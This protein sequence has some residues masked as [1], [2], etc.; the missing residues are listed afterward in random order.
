MEYTRERA[1]EWLNK[2]WN[3]P[4]S[5]PI[6]KHNNWTVS[7]SVGVMLPVSGGRIEVEGLAY[8]LFLVTCSTCGYTLFFNAVVAGFAPQIPGLEEKKYIPS[9]E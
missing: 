2:H 6:C 4:K 5:C 7:D 3:T 8:P 1:M 9:E